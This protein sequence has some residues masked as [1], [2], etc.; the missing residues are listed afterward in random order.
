MP[1]NLHASVVQAQCAVDIEPESASVFEGCTVG[2]RLT[3]IFEEGV[4][5]VKVSDRSLAPYRRD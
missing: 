2:W 1:N 5:S 3:L 4:L